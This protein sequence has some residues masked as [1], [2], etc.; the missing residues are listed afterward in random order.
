MQAGADRYH[1]CKEVKSVNTAAPIRTVRDINKFKDFYIS[2]KRNPRNYLLIVLG[3]NT[4]LRISD[5][6]ALRWNDVCEIRDRIIRKHLQL[7]EKKTSKHSVV[8]LNPQVKNALLIYIRSLGGWRSIHAGAYIFKSQKG[9]GPIGRVQA[10]RIISLA[11]KSCRIEGT[12]SPHS[13]RKTFGYHAWKEG[14]SPEL[15]MN[16]FQHSSFEITRRYL[17]ICQDD[18]DSVFKKIQL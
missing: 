15:I 13:L 3:L 16:I 4:A 2:K 5:I 8:L 7:D 12:I 18:R 14:I 6:L 9:N 17:G 1:A 11:A 10:W